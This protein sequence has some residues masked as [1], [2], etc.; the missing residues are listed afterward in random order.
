METTEADFWP[1]VSFLQGLS[2][3]VGAL[4]FSFWPSCLS[5]HTFGSIKTLLCLFITTLNY[6]KYILRWCHHQNSLFNIALR[7]RSM[8]IIGNKRSRSIQRTKIHRPLRYTLASEVQWLLH[9]C[10]LPGTRRAMFTRIC[11]LLLNRIGIPMLLK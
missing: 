2:I 8:K 11:S 7:I 1:V 3:M 9:Q 5:V 4:K 10:T 6:Q